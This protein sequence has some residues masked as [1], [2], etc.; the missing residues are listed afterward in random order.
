MSLPDLLRCII[1]Q[2]RVDKSLFLA[3]VHQVVERMHGLG[4]FACENESIL[5][6][7]LAVDDGDPL[8][9]SR[10]LVFEYL[11]D[12]GAHTCPGSPLAALIYVSGPEKLIEKLVAKTDN[13]NAY[14]K[15]SNVA[16]FQRSIRIEWRPCTHGRGQFINPLQA[17]CV[18]GEERII[19]LL[20]QDGADVNSSARGFCG[21]TPLQAVCW[22]QG[23][24]PSDAEKKT[25]IMVL[26]L[27]H[28]AKVNAAPSWNHGYTALQAAASAGDV[29]CAKLLVSRGADLNAP[30]CK[31]GGATALAIAATYRRLDMVRFLLEQGAVYHPAV[32]GL[33]PRR[34]SHED[35]S[36]VLRFISQFLPDL[37]AMIRGRAGGASPRDYHEYEA[38]WSDDPT[39]KKDYSQQ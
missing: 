21:V 32:E 3:K 25:A 7:C 35:H 39:Y 11:L 34:D 8:M 19:R 17:A 10:L 15:F 24:K 20:L 16:W 27:D 28:G 12:H 6:T 37:E 33:P 31:R 38:E 2:W 1:R 5:E 36:I 14:C 13:L 4:E 9:E 18:H 23:E 26:L 30:A 22:L 29:Q